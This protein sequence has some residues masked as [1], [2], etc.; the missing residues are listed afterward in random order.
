MNRGHALANWI[1]RKLGYARRRGQD[2]SGPSEFCGCNKY[3]RFCGIAY[4]SAR[5]CRRRPSGSDAVRPVFW[6]NQIRIA[7]ERG[8]LNKVENLSLIT[9]VAGPEA[10][11]FA[12]NVVAGPS[13]LVAAPVRPRFT[14]GHFIL[15]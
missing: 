2:I 14:H 12:V 15:R 10:L 5:M 11:Q 8:D 13:D 3:R 4:S 6:R 7:A 1:E 9:H